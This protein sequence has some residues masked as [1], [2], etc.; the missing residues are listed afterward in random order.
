MEENRSRQEPRQDPVDDRT[1]DDEILD[2]EAVDDGMT[3]DEAMAVEAGGRRADREMPDRGYELDLDEHSPVDLDEAIQEAVEAVERAGQPGGDGGE[4]PEDGAAGEAGGE[5]G[6]AATVSVEAA[7]L[8]ERLLRTL[9]DFDNYRK[10]TDREK[11]NLRRLGII[12][13]MR[14]ALSISDN[15]ARALQSA[16]GFE[17]LKQG[18]RMILRQHEEFLRRHGVEG[19]ESMGERFDPAVHEAVATQPSPEVKEP[20]VSEEL[21]KGYHFH[22]RLLRP[23]LVYVAMPA[24]APASQPSAEKVEEV[25]E[26]EGVEGR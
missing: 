22:D 25:E 12:D 9:A 1:W 4:G 18:V 10:R 17:D 3:D 20:T 7:S 24:A 11:E 13:V 16:G 15:L 2:D 8:Q 21:Q 14:D 5:S 26:A 23:A 6:S 19:F